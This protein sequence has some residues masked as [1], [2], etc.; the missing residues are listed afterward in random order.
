MLKQTVFLLCFVLLLLIGGCEEFAGDAGAEPSGVAEPT[1]LFHGTLRTD[2]M[3][4]YQKH[5]DSET[6][7]WARLPI[8]SYVQVYD[9]YVLVTRPDKATVLIKE[10]YY[11]NL[12]FEQDIV[13]DFIDP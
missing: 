8:G 11:A 10:G 7:I 2:D 9:G 1:P 5:V 3:R 13:P 12:I 6:N 4:V